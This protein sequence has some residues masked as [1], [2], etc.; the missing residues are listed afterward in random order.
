MLFH[1]FV[2][3]PRAVTCFPL[4]TAHHAELSGTATGHVIA[5]FLQFNHGGA[6]P[7][8]LPTSLF[9]NLNELFCK[10]VFGAFT[11]D[12]HSVIACT[13]DSSATVLA[14]AYFSSMFHVY[15]MRFDPLPA[16]ACGTVYAVAC[17][18]FHELSVPC[19]LELLIKQFVDVFQ[20]DMRRGA[21]S[22]RH[23]RGIIN[24]HIEDAS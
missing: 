17:R 11:R 18:V 2:V 8:F 21:T 12:V 7:A 14:S 10:G 1:S 3:E 20:W 22:W 5:S 13:A 23:V 4:A 24:G 19:F 6:F 16:P 15:I 9:G